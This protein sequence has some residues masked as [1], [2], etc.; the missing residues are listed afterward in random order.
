M[1]RRLAAREG[2]DAGDVEHALFNLTLTPSQR[3]AR[4]LA[5]LR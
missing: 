2:I 5:S 1:A 4:C 3:L